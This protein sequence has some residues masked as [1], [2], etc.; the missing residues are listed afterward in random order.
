VAVVRK[1]S[2]SFFDVWI[3]DLARG[4]ASRFT[5]G[6]GNKLFPV[7]SP[8]GG[9]IAFR[10]SGFQRANANLY[11]KATNGAAE[12][13]ELVKDAPSMRPDDWSRDG[14]YIIGET[15]AVSKS[16]TDVWVLPLFGDRKPFPYLHT[17]FNEH[18][19]RLSPNGQWLA[20]S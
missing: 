5:F 19:A 17:D 14:R 18:D 3:N 6:T 7:W 9:H 15:L 20:L 13:E 1:D 12:D 11:Q 10:S 4:T 2:Q 16:G 8:D